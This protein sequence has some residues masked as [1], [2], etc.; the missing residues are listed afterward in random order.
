MWRG[1]IGVHHQIVI[2]LKTR[3]FS[4]LCISR[5]RLSHQIV[6]GLNLDGDLDNLRTGKREG[7]IKAVAQ[8]YGPFR[9]NLASVADITPSSPLRQAILAVI[10]EARSQT[11]SRRS[12]QEMFWGSEIQ[13]KS[14]AN[15]RTAI[16]L[17]KKDLAALGD[18]I[19]KT[20][21][22]VVSL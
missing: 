7:A 13:A 11:K 5:S 6:R 8:V 21:R 2:T 12:L 4:S 18:D 19:V 3:S 20:D 14:N 1:L 10:L 15:L 16:Y 9:L 22:N 17:L